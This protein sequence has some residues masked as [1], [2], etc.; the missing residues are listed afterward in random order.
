MAVWLYLKKISVPHKFG[1]LVHGGKHEDNFIFFP[2]GYPDPPVQGTAEPFLAPVTSLAHFSTCSISGGTRDYSLSILQIF[3]NF[4]VSIV[5]I[6]FKL[7]ICIPIS[8][9]YLIK[10]KSKF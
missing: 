2:N 3:Y 1:I 10:N 5:T 7:R 9:I 8:N 6:I 4:S